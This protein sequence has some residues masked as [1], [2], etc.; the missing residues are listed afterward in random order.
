MSG[1]VGG[2]AQRHHGAGGASTHRAFGVIPYTRVTRCDGT[3]DFAVLL[4]K[5][6]QKHG[7]FW[8]FPK[9]YGKQGEGP[10]ATAL[11]EFEEETGISH[12]SA[13]TR[14]ADVRRCL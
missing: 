4:V 14:P 10:L 5:Q 11:R 1:S 9:G 2:A 12:T 8:G 6:R 7:G 3:A 13:A